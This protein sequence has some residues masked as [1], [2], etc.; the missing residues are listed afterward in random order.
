MRRARAGWPGRP[1]GPARPSVDERLRAVRRRA[2]LAAALRVTIVAGVA[3][4]VVLAIMVTGLLDRPAGQ[5]AA[6]LGSRAAL[7]IG[8]LVAL[9][10]AGIATGW[11][12]TVFWVR[13]HAR[14]RPLLL[15][16]VRAPNMSFAETV[17]HVRARVPSAAAEPRTAVTM[18]VDSA[19][20]GELSLW[21]PGRAN[22]LRRVS[23]RQLR[24]HRD[25]LLA[26]L[27]TAEPERAPLLLMRDEV[28]SV[29]PRQRTIALRAHTG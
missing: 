24:R 23:R 25:D 7:P 9:V 1:G 11:L 4:S 6:L 26:M 8:A 21:S 28:E 14:S 19:V 16:D 3:V 5:I 12:A 29:W 2:R 20:A 10:V 27:D 13:T 22:A 15:L 18:I 17:H